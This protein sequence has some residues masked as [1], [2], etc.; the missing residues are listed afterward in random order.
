MHDDDLLSQHKRLLQLVGHQN[1]G[2]GHLLL[3]PQQLRLQ[4][5]AGQ[6]VQRCERLVHQQQ[7]RLTGQHPRK[8]QPLLHAGGQLHRGQ[9]GVILQSHQTDKF[10]SPL[11]ALLRRSSHTAGHSHVALHVRPCDHIGVRAQHC[12]VPALRYHDL[13]GVRLLLPCQQLQERTLSA[14]AAS[15]DDRQLSHRKADGEVTQH[16]PRAAFTR[17]AA[18]DHLRA[19]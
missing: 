18:D 4:L 11:I 17:L 1:D 16:L 15:N 9:I 14:A 12:A 10:R 19:V 3:D 13:S 7:L 6:K 5:L 8:P 2:T